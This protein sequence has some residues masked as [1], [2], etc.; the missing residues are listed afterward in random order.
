MNRILLLAIGLIALCLPARA[1]ATLWNQTRTY[2]VDWTPIAPEQGYLDSDGGL[3]IF[4]IH[5]LGQS[6]VTR[7]PVH[8]SGYVAVDTSYLIQ[9]PWPTWVY[10][11]TVYYRNAFRIGTFGQ[12]LC[13][14]ICGQVLWGDGSMSSLAPNLDGHFVQA[15][16]PA[17][18]LCSGLIQNST[19]HYVVEPI[20]MFPVDFDLPAGVHPITVEVSGGVQTWNFQSVSHNSHAWSLEDVRHRVKAVLNV[21]PLQTSQV[22]L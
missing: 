12:Q 17:P 14:Q 1:S 8:V 9:N 2:T 13:E 19:W 11:Y 18:Y 20:I 4:T 21:G 22:L 15:P 7:V 16:N 5:D 10:E 3:P 6:I